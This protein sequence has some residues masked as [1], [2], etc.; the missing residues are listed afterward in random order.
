[1][2]L[3]MTTRI[4]ITLECQWYKIKL[5]SKIKNKEDEIIM[6]QKEIIEYY[7]EGNLCNSNNDDNHN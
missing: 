6:W 3:R 4:T 7:N 1:M 2:L 5:K